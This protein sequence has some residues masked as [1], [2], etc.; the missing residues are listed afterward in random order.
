MGAVVDD[1]HDVVLPLRAQSL[2]EEELG[3]QGA[4][5]DL[6]GAGHGDRPL[7]ILQDQEEGLLVE[8]EG[9]GVGHGR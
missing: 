1:V 2:L 3:E 7:L 9:V 6:H 5:E 8:A 4:R